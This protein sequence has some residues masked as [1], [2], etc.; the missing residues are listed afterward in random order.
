VKDLVH[1]LPTGRT[2][3]SITG[4]NQVVPPVINVVTHGTDR[5][6]I[7]AA[8]VTGVAAVVGITGTAWQ[9]KAARKTASNDLRAS[10]DAA[11]KNLRTSIGAETQRALLNDRRGVYARYLASVDRANIVTVGLDNNWSTADGN[12]SRQRRSVRQ[13]SCRPRS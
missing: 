1:G 8:V 12:G 10:L 13:P 7:V 3:G 9:A 11:A 4:V 2:G 6:A 5:P